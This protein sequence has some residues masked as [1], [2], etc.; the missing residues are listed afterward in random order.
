M[1]VREDRYVDEPRDPGLCGKPTFSEISNRIEEQ[2]WNQ[3]KQVKWWDDTKGIAHDSVFVS[4]LARE[5]ASDED[6]L[7]DSNT[8]GKQSEKPENQFF[9]AMTRLG[10]P[11][12]NLD[13]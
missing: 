7:A 6:C 13:R 2:K 10:K 8:A 11:V 5:I 1:N 9:V 3:K 4:D 12:S